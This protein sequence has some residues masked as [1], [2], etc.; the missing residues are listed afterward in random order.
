MVR[1]DRDEHAGAAPAGAR[2]TPAGDVPEVEGARMEADTPS[3]QGPGL[4]GSLNPYN[5]C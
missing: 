2:G 1:P 5:P 4:Q 3:A